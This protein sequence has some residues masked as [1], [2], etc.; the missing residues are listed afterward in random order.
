MVEAHTVDL[1]DA[2]SRWVEVVALLRAG[3]EVVLTEGEKPLARL[4]PVTPP[5]ATRVLGLHRGALRA[6]EDFDEPLAEEFW[7]PPA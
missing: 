6:R 5:A 1:A 3:T 2:P 4:V 7:L